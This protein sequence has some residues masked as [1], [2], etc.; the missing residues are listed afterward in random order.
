MLLEFQGFQ[1][2]DIQ[3]LEQILF[4]FLAHPYPCLHQHLN[5][6]SSS[7]TST[8]IHAFVGVG[9]GVR[10]K[11]FTSEFFYLKGK[12]LSGKLSCT[13]TG[14]VDLFLAWAWLAKPKA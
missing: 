11:S 5:R 4:S 3:I 10:L 13:G 12:A 9:I 1:S 7:I 14:L 8:K 2:S 6:L